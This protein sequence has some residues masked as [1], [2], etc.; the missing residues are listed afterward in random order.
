[1]ERLVRDVG[2]PSKA[3]RA[4]RDHAARGERLPGFGH[5]LYPQGDPRTTLLLEAAREIQGRAVA[6]VLALVQ[7]V[8]D[9]LGLLPTADIGL[10]AMARA[11]GMR[12]GS[13]MGL[14]A[15]GRTAG[16]V[17]HALE[18]REAGYLLRPRARYIGP[19]AP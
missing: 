11:L 13:A 7:A 12:R 16:W 9:T 4:V 6:T 2:A 19:A 5:P 10:V 18:Q 17:A 15:L 8:K 14:F 3:A 1:V